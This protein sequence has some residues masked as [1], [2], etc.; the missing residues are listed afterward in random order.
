L[1]VGKQ[2]TAMFVKD[3]GFFWSQG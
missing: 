1:I 3:D 2:G